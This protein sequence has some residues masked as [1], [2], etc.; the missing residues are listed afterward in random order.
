MLIGQ[1]A[2]NDSSLYCCVF[3]SS[4]LMSWSSKRQYTLSRFSVQAEYRGVANEVAET[5]WLQNLLWE[6]HSPLYYAI[7]VYCDNVGT[8]FL[9]S[10]PVQHQQMKHIEIEIHFVRIRL[11]QDRFAFCMYLHTIS[12]SIFWSRVFR[13]HCLMNFGQV[14]LFCVISLQLWGLL[15]A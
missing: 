5:F 1:A 9:S 2:P 12:I 14:L 8:V 4:N 13:P 6:L 10:N 15:V 11:L 7:I 3:L